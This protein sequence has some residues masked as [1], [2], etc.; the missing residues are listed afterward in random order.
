MVKCCFLSLY[1]LYLVEMTIK[2]ARLSAGR[3][4]E[5]GGDGA[6]RMAG[7]NSPAILV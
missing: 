3:G 7:F 5:G 4:G 2:L 6:G 1:T